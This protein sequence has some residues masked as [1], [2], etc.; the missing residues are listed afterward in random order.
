MRLALIVSLVLTAIGGTRSTAQAQS[1]AVDQVTGVWD[2]R[3]TL[4]KPM[5]LAKSPSR[6][7]VVGQIAMLR[8]A[9][10]AKQYGTDVG[11][12]WDGMYDVDFTPFGF[13][14]RPARRVPSVTAMMSR[15]DS[16][17]VRLNP[18]VSQGAVV[19]RGVMK[20]DSITGIWYYE[21]NRGGS[22]TFVLRRYVR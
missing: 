22:G 12:G 4:T 19:L 16:I 13:E 9:W 7:T 11:A 8:S 10:L 3:F 20:G 17:E 2:A 14:A 5:L 18:H 21:S 1:K 15:G 6:A